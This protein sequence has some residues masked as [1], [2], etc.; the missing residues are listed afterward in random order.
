MFF[1]EITEYSC[2]P[3]E[4]NSLLP[5]KANKL[6]LEKVQLQ[7]FHE[8]PNLIFKPQNQGAA[9]K[10]PIIDLAPCLFQL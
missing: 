1:V 3:P 2:H 10:P 8:E 7:D 5:T 9:N 4:A 6:S